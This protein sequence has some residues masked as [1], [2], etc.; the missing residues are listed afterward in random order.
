MIRPAFAFLLLLGLAAAGRAAA[1]L[2][3]AIALYHAHRYAEAEEL[4]RAAATAG[5]PDAEACYYLGRTLAKRND[6]AALREAAGWLEKATQLKPADAAFFSDYGSVCLQLAGREES[7]NYATKGRD[8]LEHS[9]TLDPTDLDAREGLLRFYSEAPWP[10]GS[11][12]RARAQ[13]EEI[14]RRDAARGLRAFVHLKCAEK[15]YAGV[16]SLCE[17]I[18]HDHPDDY[19]ARFEYARA[20]AKSG[21]HV[22]RALALLPRCLA[23]TPPPDYPG[24]SVV[25]FR[26]GQLHE[27]AGDPAAARADYQQAVA[28]DASNRR[29]AEALAR[30]Q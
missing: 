29:A 6:P 9:L 11:T 8:A 25:H 23:L 26:L 15:D 21:D 18:L 2:A 27:K 4:F 22:A 30:L 24:P 14:N 3:D 7:F 1:P 13:A 10:L 17:R 16:F 28:L 5:P 20:A 12:E 19:V